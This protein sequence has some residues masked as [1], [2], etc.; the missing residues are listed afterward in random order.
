[1]KKIINKIKKIFFSR[2]KKDYDLIY[3]KDCEVGYHPELLFLIN[4]P[5]AEVIKK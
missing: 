1:M 5:Y 3:E 4:L 2:S